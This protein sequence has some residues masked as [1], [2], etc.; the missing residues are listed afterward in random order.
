MHFKKWPIGSC[1]APSISINV[2]A[3][4]KLDIYEIDHQL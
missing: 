1:D 3:N 4:V 2:A